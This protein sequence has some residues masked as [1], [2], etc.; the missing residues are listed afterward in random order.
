MATGMI[1][2]MTTPQINLRRLLDITTVITL[3]M[4]RHFLYITTAP[5]LS[6]RPPRK[7]AAERLRRVG[8]GWDPTDP[9]SGSG[10][11]RNIRDELV[12]L[13]VV[14][15]MMVTMMTMMMTTLIMSLLMMGTLEKKRTKNGLETG[16]MSKGQMVQ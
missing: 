12:Q 7:V 8:V 2:S 9:S 14:V 1:V 6:K 15:L 4:R 3:I 16:E 10:S 5:M 13:A 11:S